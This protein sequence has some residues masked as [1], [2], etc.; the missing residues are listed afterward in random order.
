MEY[1]IPGTNETTRQV[2]DIVSPLAPGDTPE[3][4]HFTTGG[5]EKS[6]VMLNIFMGFEM[7][8]EQAARNDYEGALAI[9]LPL[10]NAVDNWVSEIP[11]EDIRDDLFY[12]RLFIENLRTAN[13]PEPEDDPREPW[14]GD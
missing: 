14:P 4:G 1:T 8:A 2:A 3:G 11:D 12:L 5:V 7:A 9:L 10:A 13:A 6:F